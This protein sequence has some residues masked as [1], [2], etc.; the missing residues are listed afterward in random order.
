MESAIENQKLALAFT[1]VELL[2]VIT[3]IVVLLALLVPAL[4]EAVYQADLA[5]CATHQH[6]IGVGA[7]AYALNHARIPGRPIRWRWSM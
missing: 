6:G 7:V 4:D 2:V 5:V 3:I 1:F